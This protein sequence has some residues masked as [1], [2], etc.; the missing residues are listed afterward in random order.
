MADRDSHSWLWLQIRSLSGKN[1]W[2]FHPIRIGLVY[3]LFPNILPLELSSHRSSYLESP[4]LLSSWFSVYPK[5]NHR[6]IAN[7]GSSPSGKT[8]LIL[9]AIEDFLCGT[10]LSSYVAGPKS[11]INHLWACFSV[12]FFL[13][14]FPQWFIDINLTLSETGILEQEFLK[15]QEG[16]NVCS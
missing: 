13:I 12:I 1:F 16:L 6:K 11:K 8:F 10:P 7:S 15:M 5:S 14:L 9:L 3:S 4:L 2:V